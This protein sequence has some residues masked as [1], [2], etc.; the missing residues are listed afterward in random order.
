MIV[1]VVTGT[2]TLYEPNTTDVVGV[3]TTRQK[4]E[5]AY[6]KVLYNYDERDICAV[7]LDDMEI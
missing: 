7:K 5:E 3:Y 6:D 2:G 1:Y 4:A